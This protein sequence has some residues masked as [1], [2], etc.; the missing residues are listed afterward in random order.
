MNEVTV[1]LKER[2]YK[3]II[4]N[5]ILDSIGNEIKQFS[6]SSK[7]A[8]ISNPTVFALYGERVI[9]SLSN[10][11]FD[12]IKILIDDGEEYKNLHSYAYIQEQLLK[13]RLDRK[14]AIIALGGGVIGDMAGFCAATY[15][16][17]ISFIQI[18]TTLLA[19]VDSSVGGKTGV[20]H[21]LGKNMI[22]AFY[23]P[24]LVLIDIA[25][26]KSL[27]KREFLAG[28]AEVIKYGIIYDSGF[29]NY[30]KINKDEIL[31]LNPIDLTHIIKRSCEIKAEV[32]SQD[33][34]EAGLRAILNFG[35]TIGHAIETATHYK[36]YL[37]G[38]AIAIGMCVESKLSSISDEE[39]HM[40][41]SL[42]K[43]Y[44]L[45]SEIP[46]DINRDTILTVMTHDKKAVSGDIKFVLPNKIGEVEIKG[47][48]NKEKIIQALELK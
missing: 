10:A 23:Q 30:L 37:H 28:M 31:N 8:L 41:I 36:R 20:N 1:N 42:I 35:H 15:M 26:L 21:P 46:D 6:F 3:I 40:I 2:S 19:Q 45:P 27:P 9:K 12:V 29:F 24:K 17:G 47:G 14:S 5:G 11:G 18:P 33:E 34:R 25:V 4:D 22:G 13:N 48:I 44:G 38:E 7:I 32:V 43:S 16:R 39:F